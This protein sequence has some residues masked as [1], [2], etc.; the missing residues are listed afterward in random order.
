MAAV[1]SLGCVYLF[2]FACLL[3]FLKLLVVILD[4]GASKRL[5]IGWADLFIEGF[6]YYGSLQVALWYDGH[7]AAALKDGNLKCCKAL[8]AAARRSRA[9]A[10]VYVNALE[11]VS[12]TVVPA[13]DRCEGTSCGSLPVQCAATDGHVLGLRINEGLKPHRE[14]GPVVAGCLSV[15]Y[16]D[17]ATGRV[18]VPRRQQRDVLAGNA[19]SFCGHF[20]RFRP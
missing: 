10:S 6:S 11:D 19:V 14:D 17:Q 2:L 18:D 3:A 5:K 13:T 7:A 20:G 9:T 4:T 8:S 1:A 16:G 15:G 12:S